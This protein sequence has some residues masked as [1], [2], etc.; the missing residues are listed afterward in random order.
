MFENEKVAT[1]I[2][3]TIIKDG[4]E[5]S[6]D[7]VN[8]LDELIVNISQE[9]ISDYKIHIE[10]RQ[11]EE[12]KLREMLIQIYE[13]KILDMSS[14]TNNEQSDETFIQSILS[15][16]KTI[17]KPINN[18]KINTLFV[19][20]PDLNETSILNIDSSVFIEKAKNYE[21]KKFQARQ[22]LKKIQSVL[23][24][25]MDGNDEDEYFEFDADYE[26][27]GVPDTSNLE[28]RNAWDIHSKCEIYSS[29]LKKWFRGEVIDIFVD[30]EGEWLKIKYIADGISKSKQVQRYN[31]HIRPTYQPR[32]HTRNSK[33]WPLNQ[34]SNIKSKSISKLNKKISVRQIASFMNNNS[35][36]K[37][38]SLSTINE[39]VY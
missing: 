28:T 8:D 17:P 2:Y 36:R 27:Y 25:P 3:N 1:T 33:L 26:K 38:Q 6:K 11:N 29:S 9:I 21:I 15:I 14:Y 23:A 10:W 20:D 22:L 31:D 24:C 37:Y 7:L 16:N 35:S 13:N 39:Q 12:N 34:V 19:D 32:S 18:K 5:E 30:D 4:Y